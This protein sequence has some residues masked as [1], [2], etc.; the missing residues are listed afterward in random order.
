MDNETFGD[1]NEM[2]FGDRIYDS[3]IGRWLSIDPFFKK[4]AYLSPYVACANNPISLVDI[5]GDSTAYYTLSGVLLAKSNDS[6]PDAIVIIDDETVK[7]FLILW[8]WGERMGATHKNKNADFFRSLGKTYEVK[9]FKDLYQSS[10]AE[11][12]KYQGYTT[13]DGKTTETFTDLN[14][15]SL[16]NEIEI[17]LKDV[18]GKIIPFG[19]KTIG[20]P[21]GVNTDKGRKG[22]VATAHSHPNVGDA[23]KVIVEVITSSPFGPTEKT[24]KKPIKGNQGPSGGPGD[25]QYGD[26]DN[27]QALPGYLSVVAE[28][29]TLYF[30]DKKD[31]KIIF[32][33]FKNAK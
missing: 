28:R 30:Y 11:D 9:I 21:F 27:C 5:G 13:P 33:N 26:I 7:G 12:N 25:P 3:R 16:Y 15:N 18:K 20:S 17:Y 4:Y 14:G 19:E 8:S 23:I 24:T 1:G 31:T 32:H 22:A 2:D 29:N 10:L 6:R